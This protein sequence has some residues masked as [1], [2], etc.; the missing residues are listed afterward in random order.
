MNAWKKELVTRAELDV[1]GAP[2]QPIWFAN[3]ERNYYEYIRDYLG[4]RI[5]CT[6]LTA[7]NITKKKKEFR[8][9]FVNH[10]FAAPVGLKEVTIVAVD[11]SGK[12][13]KKSAP[14]CDLSALQTN[15][16]ITGRV[17]LDLQKVQEKVSFGIYLSDK[18]GMGNRLA[19]DCEFFCGVNLF[20]LE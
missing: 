11:K 5:E 6:S 14:I 18:A 19:N 16:E 7:E 9:S 2:Y 20:E 17:V 10:G 4:Y 15:E 12:I 8:F 1:L 13:L 3:G